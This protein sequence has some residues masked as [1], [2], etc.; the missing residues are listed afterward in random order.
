MKS[1]VILLAG[2]SGKRLW[3]ISDEVR[4]KQ[5]LPFLQGKSMFQLVYGLIK[6]EFGKE[7]IVVA[8]GVKQKELVAKQIDDSIAVLGEPARRDTFAAIVLATAYV[9]KYQNKGIDDVV[10]V[11]P[12]DVKTEKSYA[13]CIKKMVDLVASNAFDL[14]LMGIKKEKPSDQVGYIVPEEKNSEYLKVKEF[15]EKPSIEKGEK[16]LKEGAVIN[17]GVFAFKIGY[18]EKIALEKFGTFDYDQLYLTY[19]KLEAISFDYAVVEKAEEIGAVLYEGI[20]EDLGTWDSLSKELGNKKIGAQFKE[21]CENTTIIN[22]QKIPVVA[23]GVADLIIVA[24]EKGILVTK[25]GFTEELKS[26]YFD[27]EDK[28]EYT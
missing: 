20:W 15:V 13:Q 5:F 18:L 12:T 11:V 3:P 16:L 19:E 8:T 2:G 26:R 9:K 27:F 21:K 14:V 28:G 25:E 6:E 23:L 17:G 24:S 7:N 1:S 22:E 10:A 4:S